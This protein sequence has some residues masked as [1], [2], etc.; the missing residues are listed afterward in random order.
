[1][2]TES[3]VVTCHQCGISVL[4]S[5]MSFPKKP[6]GGITKCLLFSQVMTTAPRVVCFEVFLYTLCKWQ[7]KGTTIT[8]F[9]VTFSFLFHV[10]PF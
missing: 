7:G 8:Y 9:C 5:Q 2:T 6:C 10:R 3:L 4:V 1:M